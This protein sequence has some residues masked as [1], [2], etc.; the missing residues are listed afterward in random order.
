MCSGFGS[1]G[2]VCMEGRGDKGNRVR[3]ARGEG[4]EKTGVSA[5]H[6]QL[7]GPLYLVPPS[8]YAHLSMVTCTHIFGNC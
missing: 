1:V 2:I 4:G 3:G 7:W 6:H 8:T 5:A